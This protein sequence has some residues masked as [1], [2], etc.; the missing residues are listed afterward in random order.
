MM[1]ATFCLEMH[2]RAV[3]RK[4]FFLSQFGGFAVGQMCKDEAGYF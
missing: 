2:K 1:G 4:L 3:V